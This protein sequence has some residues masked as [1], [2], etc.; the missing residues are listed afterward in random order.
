MWGYYDAYTAAQIELMAVD[1]PMVVYNHDKEKGKKGKDGQS[2]KKANAL[3][4]LETASEWKR[5]YG[6][7]ASPTNISIDLKGFKLEA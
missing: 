3:D 1:A 7:G 6:D 4:I 2:F 5:K